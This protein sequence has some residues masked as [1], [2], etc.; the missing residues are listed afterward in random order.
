MKPGSTSTNSSTGGRLG[1]APPPAAYQEK[2]KIK[3]HTLGGSKGGFWKPDLGSEIHGTWGGNTLILW[4]ALLRRPKGTTSGH[5][6][7]WY[8]KPQTHDHTSTHLHP[9]NPHHPPTRPREGG[10]GSHPLPPPIRK[11]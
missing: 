6:T 7:P 4:G 1:I 2:L 8:A 10:S 9:R 11:N 3:N 5:P